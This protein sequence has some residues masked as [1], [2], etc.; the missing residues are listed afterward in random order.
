MTADQEP[1]L[2]KLA[3]LARVSREALDDGVEI[4]PAE[5]DSVDLLDLIAAVDEAFGVT[6][7][8]KEMNRC[9]T[10][11]ELRTLVEAARVQR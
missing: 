5:W 10:V 1:F 2:A 7:D 6:V 3:D 8:I 4:Q 11:G 9:K